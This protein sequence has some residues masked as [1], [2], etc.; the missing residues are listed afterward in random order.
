M[1]VSGIRGQLLQTDDEWA[2]RNSFLSRSLAELVDVYSSAVARS[3]IE[4]GCQRGAL[5]DQMGKCS[6]PG[7]GESAWIFRP[8]LRCSSVRQ[9]FRAHPPS[10]AYGQSSGNLPSAE[11]GRNSCRADS[12]SVFSDRVPQSAAV[13]G[14]ATEWFTASVLETGACRLGA[15]LLCRHYQ[16]SPFNCTGRRL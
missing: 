12:E 11:V 1:T 4:I 3:G 2:A 10:R 16:T 14:L 7:A 8:Y 6:A 9:C 13:D 15:R 5:T